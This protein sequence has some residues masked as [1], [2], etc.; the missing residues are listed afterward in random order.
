MSMPRAGSSCFLSDGP[1]A[2]GFAVLS[3]SNDQHF[4]VFIRST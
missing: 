1:G 4:L 2:D 3:A